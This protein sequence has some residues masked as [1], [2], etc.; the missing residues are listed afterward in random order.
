MLS[1]ALAR[2]VGKVP[3]VSAND[4]RSL[5]SYAS[6]DSLLLV[7]RVLDGRFETDS[8]LDLI[9]RLRQRPDAPAMMLISNYAEAQSEA[10]RAG[11]LPGFGKSNAHDPAT[12]DMLRQAVMVESSR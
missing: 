2:A 6:G 4:A 12:A 1:Y 7:N 11:A 10:V 8:G 5:E 3:V 9:A